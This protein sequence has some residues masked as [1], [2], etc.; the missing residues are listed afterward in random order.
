M[1]NKVYLWDCSSDRCA[2]YGSGIRV[3]TGM[4]V[5]SGTEV[6]GQLF[7]ETCQ[8]SSQIMVINFS[9]LKVKF[10]TMW[11]VIVEVT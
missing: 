9:S 10:R 4:E 7:Q 6:T 1:K 11:E 3:H 2:L 8:T 5:I